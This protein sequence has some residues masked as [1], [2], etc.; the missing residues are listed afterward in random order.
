MSQTNRTIFW[1]NVFLIALDERKTKNKAKRE[2]YIEIIY[3]GKAAKNIYK[4]KKKQSKDNILHCIFRDKHA[5]IL[6]IYKYYY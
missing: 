5:Q 2:K 1:L 4:R 3:A 6:T